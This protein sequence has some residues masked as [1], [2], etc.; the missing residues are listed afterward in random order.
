MADRDDKDLIGAAKMNR[1]GL[2]KC[3]MAKLRVGWTVAGCA[4]GVRTI[5][6]SVRFHCTTWLTG[7][8]AWAIA[9]ARLAAAS[10]ATVAPANKRVFIWTSLELT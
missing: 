7:F 2:L 3:M 4:P 1:R 9:G 5:T 10:A 8:V 6:R